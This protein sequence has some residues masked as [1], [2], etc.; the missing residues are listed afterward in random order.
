VIDVFSAV[1]YTSQQFDVFA[2]HGVDKYLTAYGLCV[3]PDYRGRGIATQI[4][5]ARVPILKALGLSV[6][7]TAFTGIGSQ[8]A[9]KKAGFKDAYVISYADLEKAVPGFDFSKSFT[10]SF[11]TMTLCI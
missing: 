2:A 10:K 5:K 8:T 11:K 7:A 3:N 6:T 4:L 1:S 9:A